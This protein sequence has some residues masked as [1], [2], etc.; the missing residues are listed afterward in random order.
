MSLTKLTANLNN[1]QSLPDKPSITTD[2]L[3]AVFD[4]AGNA[5]KEYLNATMT[6]E[7]DNLISGLMSDITDDESAITALNTLTTTMKSKL[8]GIENNANKYVHPTTAGN[9]HIPSGGASGQ[10]LKWSSNGTA[11]WAAEKDTTYNPATTSANG[12]MSKEDKT[13]LD[14]ITAGANKYVHPTGAGN[15]HI[16]SGG[17]SGQILKWSSA[18]VAVWAAEKDTTYGV[19]TASTNGLMSAAMFTK[20]NGIAAEANKYVHPTTAGN[21]HIPSGGS[22]GQILRWSASG[23]AKWGNENNTTYNDATTSVHGLMSTADKTKLNGIAAGATKNVIS[24]GTAAP[25]GGNNGDIYIQY[26]T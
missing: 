21:K 25:T 9:K 12:L 26:F 18:G 1:V 10:I 5:I 7:I 17:A 8:D 19:A 2:E 22:S 15:N 6:A 3:K 13:K 23:E 16:P 11:V 20:L 4:A 14:G 24:V